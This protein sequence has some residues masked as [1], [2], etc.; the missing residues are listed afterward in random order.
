MTELEQ[1]L[2]D[3]KG[4][5]PGV[6][7]IHYEMLKN[8]TKEGK[9]KFLDLCNRI[10]NERI[11]PQNWRRSLA[12]PIPKP[13]KDAK[14]PESYRFIQLTNCGCKLFERMVNKRLQWYLETKNKLN[15]AQFGFRKD[16]S[17][18]DAIIQLSSDI[19]KSFDLKQQTT[20]VSFDL[21]KAYDMTWRHKVFLEL[22]DMGLGGN[23]VHY[24][25]NFLIE[26]KVQIL[27]GKS[28]SR[29]FT[30]ETGLPQGSVLS[31]TLF[32]IVANLL[33]KAAGEKVGKIMYA[34]D[35]TIYTSNKDPKTA[36][37]T[38]Q[39]SIDRVTRKAEE[40]GFEFSTE[41]TKAIFFS[42]GRNK[43]PGPEL[44]CKNQTLKY[45]DEIRI[46]GMTFTR[47]LKWNKHLRDVGERAKKRLNVL[48]MLCNPRFGAKRKH[49]LM[50]LQTTVLSTLEYGSIVYGDACKSELAKLNTIY[51]NGIRI[52][53]GAF[54]TSPVQSLL[55]EAGLLPL[56]L[57]RDQQLL[58]LGNK[59]RTTVDHP[60]FNDF[61]KFENMSV[62]EWEKIKKKKF[63]SFE[64]RWLERFEKLGVE[65]N[66]EAEDK[67]HKLPPWLETNIK[68]DI[69]LNNNKK[70]ETNQT[71]LKN[72]TTLKLSKHKRK[73][74]MYTDGSKT[75]EST[76]WAVVTPAHMSKDRK[77]KLSNYESI[78]TAEL[79]AISNAIEIG[80]EWEGQEEF[81][82]VSDSL[83]AVLSIQD[84]YT[85]NSHVQKIHDQLKST[86]KKFTL[87]W[88]PSHIGISGNEEADR[89]AKNT[90]NL[91][92]INKQLNKLDLKALMKNRIR[93][94][95]DQTWTAQHDNKLFNIKKDVKQYKDI[96]L[97]SR[98]EATKLTRLRIGH[99]KL[100][101]EYLL[102]KSEPPECKCGLR[103]TVKHLFDCKLLE[104][105]RKANNVNGIHDL[106]A[107]DYTKN[108]NVIEF[109]RTIGAL[110][111]L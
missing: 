86:N 64:I 101:H 58:N 52:A 24:I 40:L 31:T 41:K 20:A 78:M 82:I 22:V 43:K 60:M 96:N 95:W 69:T 36:E 47:N 67:W 48:R 7:E 77:G 92:I 61:Q 76:G 91:E 68:I 107:D 104:E 51:N 30:Q 102:K 21:K 33:L 39:S 79:K 35:L 12:I 2:R 49:L 13:G 75:D 100:T 54:R 32:L 38:M 26:R 37:K 44:R 6:D 72:L 55:I 9:Q 8:L 70:R 97:F 94:R 42:P 99:T 50:L 63:K 45:E 18:M 1:A 80:S 89:N 11:F 56:E 3:V 110:H 105:A 88:I 66:S 74:I 90:N 62:E 27:V 14:I 106:E 28:T 98:Y 16:R 84:I 83:S 93:A 111:C 103:G 23:L 25:E 108:R 34:D 81:A 5:S 53:T 87:I 109:L 46:L 19:N 15:V 71:Q 29:E 57:R 59:I 4:T 65:L 73:I 10:W 17:T 85:R